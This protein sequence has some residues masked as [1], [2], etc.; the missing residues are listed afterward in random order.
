MK[1]V[2]VAVLA[3]VAVAVAA[4]PQGNP[5]EPIAILRQDFEQ[6]PEGNYNS[7]WE[8]ENGISAQETGELKSVRD[9]E[10]KEQQVVVVRGSY[11]YTDEEGKQ[12]SVTYYADETGFHAESDDIPVAPAARR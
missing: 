3:V 1:L 4:P 8:T 9:E 6:S 11:S 2:I 7:A 5:Q 10:N 12:H